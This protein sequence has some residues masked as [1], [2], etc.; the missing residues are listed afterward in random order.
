MDTE[1]RRYLRPVLL[2]T[3]RLG[4]AQRR[5]AEIAEIN[6]ALLKSAG[7]SVMVLAELMIEADI[8]RQRFRDFRA[9][10]GGER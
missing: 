3:T 6:P 1:P 8:K 4:V 7:R 9:A 10:G 5:L 2:R